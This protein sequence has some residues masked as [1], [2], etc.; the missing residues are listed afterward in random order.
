MII[1]QYNRFNILMLLIFN[2]SSQVEKFII[3]NQQLNTIN[4]NVCN[5]IECMFFKEKFSHFN[6][7]TWSYKSSP[8]VDDGV[9]SNDHV[10]AQCHVE[11]KVVAVADVKGIVEDQELGFVVYVV[12]F[13]SNL[14]V[15]VNRGQ[16]DVI[17]APENAR[18]DD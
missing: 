14:V 1:F 4:E 12:A 18:Q 17:N 15:E 6:A 9:E 10:D 11:G 16:W 8:R 5:N 13:S 2:I 3:I 7:Y